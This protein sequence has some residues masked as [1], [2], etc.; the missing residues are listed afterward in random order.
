MGGTQSIGGGLTR[1]RVVLDTASVRAIS[2][3]LHGLGGCF[4]DAE[5]ALLPTRVDPVPALVARLAAKVAA[6]QI[7]EAS[8]GMPCEPPTFRGRVVEFTEPS[9]DRAALLRTI[10]VLVSSTGVPQLHLDSIAHAGRGPG[11]VSLS[12]DEGLAAA[13]VVLVQVR[14]STSVT[15]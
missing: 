12:H 5:T 4:T 14:S 10:Q 2:S 9:P 6:A 13:L 15:I 1:A 11:W 3:P 7:L 8:A